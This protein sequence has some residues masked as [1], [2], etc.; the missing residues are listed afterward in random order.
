[1]AGIPQQNMQDNPTANSMK[2]M[3][4]VMPFVTGVMC[5][6]FPIGVGLYWV[7]GNVF[8]I[9]QQ[10]FINLYFSKVD[11]EEMLAKNADNQQEYRITA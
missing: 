11:M 7:A 8:R 4:T 2:T 10:L 1:M 5:F 6:M 3:N 9:F